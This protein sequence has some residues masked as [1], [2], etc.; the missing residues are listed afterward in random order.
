MNEA[1]YNLTNQICMKTGGAE[2]LLYLS[3]LKFFITYKI[4]QNV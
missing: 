3:A 2:N 1:Y 4:N